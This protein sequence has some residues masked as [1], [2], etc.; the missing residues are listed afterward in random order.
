MPPPASARERQTFVLVHGAWHGA[1]CWQ[2][3]ADLLRTQGHRVITPTLAGLGERADLLSS[4]IT[5]DTHIADIVD[6]FEREHLQN[7]V[8]VA[9][10][11]AGWPA[12]GALERIHERISTLVFLDAHLPQDGDRGIDTSNHQKEIIADR[13]DGKAGIDPPQASEF[14]EKHITWVQSM[15]TP[16]PIGVY[17]QPIHL[18][19]A[20]ERIKHKLYMRTTGYHSP[21]FDACRDTA[22]NNGWIV[23]D[24]SCAHDMMI[25]EPELLANILTT[26]AATP[27]AA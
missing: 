23:Q 19:G 1:W 14:T 16:H 22:R 20:R 12:S 3:V 2:E 5:L 11:Y 18:T 4:E 15:M 17:L 7:A 8:L 24:V 26:L 9:H 21:R 13:E 27:L 10:S 6:V 25:D